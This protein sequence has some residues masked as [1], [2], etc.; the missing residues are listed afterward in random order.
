MDINYSYNLSVCIFSVFS[1]HVNYSHNNGYTN[2][3]YVIPDCVKHI[4]LCPPTVLISHDLMLLTTREARVMPLP[5]Q[6][7]DLFSKV[8]LLPTSRATIG[9]LMVN[10]GGTHGFIPWGIKVSPKACVTKQDLLVIM[11]VS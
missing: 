3:I 2:Y 4:W 1:T 5:A 7:H 10:I 8:N 9:V 11:Q 6:S